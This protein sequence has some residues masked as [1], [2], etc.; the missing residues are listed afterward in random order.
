MRAS[1]AEASPDHRPAKMSIAASIS[2]AAPMRS[3]PLAALTPAIP[4][5][6]VVG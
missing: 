2:G 3:T 4:A 5:V 6:L 1:S